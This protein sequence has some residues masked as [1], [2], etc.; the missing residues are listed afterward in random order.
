MRRKRLSRHDLGEVRTAFAR[1][2]AAVGDDLRRIDELQ[3]AVLGISSRSHRAPELR[4]PAQELRA[5]VRRAS[6][7]VSQTLIEVGRRFPGASVHE[8]NRPDVVREWQDR[9]KRLNDIDNWLSFTEMS[10]LGVEEPAAVQIRSRAAL[11]P[12]IP[13]LESG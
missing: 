1:L 5:A 13:G 12:H 10:A 6:T 11:G 7:A 9:L 8:R 4:P 2:H 3:L